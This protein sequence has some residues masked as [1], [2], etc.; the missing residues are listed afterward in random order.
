MVSIT[1]RYDEMEKKVAIIWRPFYL[2]ILTHADQFPPFARDVFS[3]QVLLL[4]FD[5]S[6]IISKQEILI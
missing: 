2:E 5:S 6:G 1:E 3:K 4:R